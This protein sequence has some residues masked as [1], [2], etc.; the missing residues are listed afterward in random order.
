MANQSGGCT[1]GSV[2]YELSSDPLFT[3]VCHCIECQHDSGGAF[4]VS[5]LVLSSGFEITAGTP[6]ISVI[7]RKSRIEYEVYSCTAC[8]SVLAGNS[9][10]P[11]EVMVVR[12]GTLDDMSWIN[13]QAHIWT[14]EKQSWV[15]IPEN[16]PSFEEG[17][18][19]ARVWPKASL[20]RVDNTYNQIKEMRYTHSLLKASKYSSR[21][22]PR[23]F[24][25]AITKNRRSR[26][27]SILQMLAARII[28]LCESPDSIA[29]HDRTW[30]HRT[31]RQCRIH[32]KSYTLHHQDCGH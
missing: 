26:A 3:H 30:L 10:P 18:D 27:D 16:I 6:N 11:G 21:S 23:Q 25:A 20:D 24:L 32:R 2:R 31:G 13:P 9:L 19:A 14:K 8:L 22:L 28:G 29:D 12:P 17:Y 15:S 1:C 5:L 4:N 7:S